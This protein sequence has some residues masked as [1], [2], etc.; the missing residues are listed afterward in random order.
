MISSDFRAEARRKLDGRW[1]KAV[2]LVLGYLA[3]MFVLGFIEGLFPEGS[4]VAV[5]WSLITTIIEIPISFGLI[6]SFLRFYKGEDVK[7]FDFLQSSIDNFK[8]SWAVTWYVFLKMIIPVIFIFVSMLIMTGGAIATGVSTNLM[9]TTATT[10]FGF[11]TVIGLILMIVGYIWIIPLSYSYK[12][13]YYIAADNPEMSTKEAVEKSK[14][15]M[16]GK[17]WKLF[18]LEFSFIGWAFL[19]VLTFGIGF[20]WL[21]PYIVIST[22]AFYFFVAGKNSTV[23]T[24]VTE[25]VKPEVIQE[26]NDDNGPIEEK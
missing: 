22:L 12:M 3:I 25:E 16:D 17:R 21:M 26:S 5:V 11:L 10:G 9:S 7:A 13:A 24:T 19:A 14:E 18:C 6:I 4:A 8:R 23:E 15:L 20:L 1:G 2:V